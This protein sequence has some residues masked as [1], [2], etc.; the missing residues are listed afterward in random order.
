[1]RIYLIFVSTAVGLAMLAG[2]GQTP[3]T[4]PP[5]T[6]PAGTISGIVQSF[7]SGHRDQLTPAGKVTVTAYRKAFPVFGPVLARGPKPVAKA[8]TDA[9]G[10]FVLRGLTEGRYFVVV[11]G[12]PSAHWVTLPLGEGAATRFAT[13]A[14]CPL[15]M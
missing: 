2:C 5:R 6:H 15:P 9:S 12:T 11:S 14:D 4:S 8:T 7:Y 13:C 1:M 10:R 3:T